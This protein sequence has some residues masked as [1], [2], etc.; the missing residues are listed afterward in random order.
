[1]AASSRDRALFAHT[2]RPIPEAPCHA[3]ACH[4]C[5]PPHL[6]LAGTLVRL[7]SGLSHCATGD[8]SSLASAGIP[9]LLALAIWAW[10]P[11][12]PCGPASA[13][14]PYGSEEPVVG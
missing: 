13:R 9:A 1:M 7:A 6:G 14:P 2:A 3:P 12:N 11:A 8:L 4:R 5:H 10:M